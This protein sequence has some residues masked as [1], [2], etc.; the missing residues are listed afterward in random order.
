MKHLNASCE[1]NK[2]SMKKENAKKLIMQMYFTS[3]DVFT[4]PKETTKRHC[5]T[6]KDA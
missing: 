3:S 5:C 1:W 2:N 6:S 4:K